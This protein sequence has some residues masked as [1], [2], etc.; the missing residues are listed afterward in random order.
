VCLCIAVFDGHTKVVLRKAGVHINPFPVHVHHS[1]P[2]VGILGTSTQ[3]PNDN[4]QQAREGKN[5]RYRV[6]QIGSFIEVA[7]GCVGVLLHTNAMRVQKAKSGVGDGAA[8]SS[9]CPKVLRCYCWI[10]SDPSHRIA[11]T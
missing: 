2:V 1:Q 11:C 7:Q 9:R 4:V 3:P 10:W 5:Q 8:L 6:T